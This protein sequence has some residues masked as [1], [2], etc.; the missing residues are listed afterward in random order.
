VE[1]MQWLLID[2]D[3]DRASNVVGGPEGKDRDGRRAIAREEELADSA[4]ASRSHPQIRLDGQRPLP[5]RV[6]RG[7]QAWFV[8]GSPDG[9]SELTSI[10]R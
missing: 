4:V 5:L 1:Q 7:H 8:T 6:V 9:L 3:A 2:R 10:S